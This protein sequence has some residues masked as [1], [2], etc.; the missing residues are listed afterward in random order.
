LYPNWRGKFKGSVPSLDGLNNAQV[1]EA[2]QRGLLSNIEL[3]NLLN[4]I[5]TPDSQFLKVSSLPFYY[6]ISLLSTLP[7][8][9]DS[10]IFWSP[11]TRDSLFC[12]L[13]V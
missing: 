11:Q 9:I 2:L 8:D 6:L 5:T 10:Q 13:S 12:K 7:S 1:S 4:L 3:S